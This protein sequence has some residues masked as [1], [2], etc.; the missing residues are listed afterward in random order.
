MHG[1]EEH[2]YDAVA[3]YDLRQGRTCGGIALIVLAM[4]WAVSVPAAA[5]TEQEQR[6][7][8]IYLTGTSTDPQSAI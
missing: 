3:S 5:L 4:L 2:C 8:Q 1:R 7:E 6:G